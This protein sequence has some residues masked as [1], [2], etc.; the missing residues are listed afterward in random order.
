[1]KE[2]YRGP[3]RAARASARMCCPRLAMPASCVRISTAGGHPPAPPASPAQAHPLRVA[4]FC[5]PLPLEPSAPRDAHSPRGRLP[6]LIS[7]LSIPSHNLDGKPCA[8]PRWHSSRALSIL[9]LARVR[10]L[11]LHLAVIVH[12]PPVLQHEASPPTARSAL[13]LRRFKALERLIVDRQLAAAVVESA[14]R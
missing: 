13:L 2:G 12:L 7:G 1:M 11:A 4:T 6:V 9:V 8:S 14:K 10:N 3:R 5:A